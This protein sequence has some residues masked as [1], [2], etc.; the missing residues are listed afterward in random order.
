MTR[1]PGTNEASTA[2]FV[3]LVRTL[4]VLH[5]GRLLGVP[6]CSWR[7]PPPSCCCVPRREMGA[8]RI[9]PLA[10]ALIQLLGLPDRY[11]MLAI[12]CWLADNARR[13]PGQADMAVSLAFS[14]GAKASGKKWTTHRALLQYAVTVG[15]Q[16]MSTRRKRNAYP[17]CRG[18]LIRPSLFC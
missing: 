1:P 18:A 15:H 3:G 11:F 5:V 17:A 16:R 10:S 14:P 9:N 6:C 13:P 7:T 2:A 4:Y 8:V 12:S